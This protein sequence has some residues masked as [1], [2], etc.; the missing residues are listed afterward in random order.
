[1]GKELFAFTA[2]PYLTSRPEAKPMRSYR[3]IALMEASSRSSPSN[4]DLFVSFFN[5]VSQP[6][7]IIH[8]GCKCFQ[9]HRVYQCLLDLAKT[10]EVFHFS[11]VNNPAS[12][13]AFFIVIALQRLAPSRTW[14]SPHLARSSTLHSETRLTRGTM[15]DLP[16]ITTDVLHFCWRKHATLN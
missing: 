7:E 11:G 4:S 16:M 6:Q 1:M 8:S 15:P 14:A 12:A 3:F 2:L 13:D 10:C 9:S 5:A